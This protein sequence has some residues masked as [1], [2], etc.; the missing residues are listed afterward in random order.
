M[1]V[2]NMAGIAHASSWSTRFLLAAM[3]YDRS[4]KDT[5]QTILA[6]ITW[7]MHVLVTGVWPTTDGAGILFFPKQL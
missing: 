6:F 7:S 1:Y 5:F 4:T 3:P 2:F